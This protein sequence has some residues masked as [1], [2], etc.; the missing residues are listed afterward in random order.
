MIQGRI[1]EVKKNI[2][3]KS[4]INSGGDHDG[5]VMEPIHDYIHENVTYKVE[6]RFYT[7]MKIITDRLRR[8][9]QIYLKTR[10]QLCL[11]CL[12]YH[13]GDCDKKTCFKCG[14][15]GHLVSQCPYKYDKLTCFKCGKK[16][17]KIYDCQVVIISSNPMNSF[18]V[19]REPISVE[20][21]KRGWMKEELKRAK[22]VQCGS[23]SH[24]YCTNDHFTKCKDD[25]IYKGE[26]FFGAQNQGQNGGYQNQGIMGG[27]NGLGGLFGGGGYDC[28]GNFNRT[29][30]S[31]NNMPVG[32]NSLTQSLTLN[33][34]LSNN[35]NAYNMNMQPQLNP[36][37]QQGHFN[38]SSNYH[39][40]HG[41]SNNASS[42]PLVGRMRLNQETHVQSYQNNSSARPMTQFE[43]SFAKF[44]RLGDVEQLKKRAINA[45]FQADAKM[46]QMEKKRKIA[47]SES[48]EPQ[49]N[50][51]E[52]N[53]L[54]NMP[55]I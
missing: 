28:Y 30:H 15:L 31:Q 3:S 5:V 36:Q 27:Y 48:P 17:H 52:A 49:Q 45:F 18:S 42:R 24:L 40:Q 26:G 6:D 32:R 12:D 20:S 33:Q 39:S 35:R 7:K 44:N 13:V 2:M 9:H 8:E 29:N 54:M 43:S 50:V 25:D 19:D 4:T 38:N 22:C 51:Q 47:S 37:N 21:Q 55:Q 23:N 53:K 14:R 41:Y 46:A 11:H 1:F 34:R 16:G 10:G